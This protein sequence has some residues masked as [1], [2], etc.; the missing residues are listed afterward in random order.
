MMLAVAAEDD[1]AGPGSCH[2]VPLVPTNGLWKDYCDFVY[3]RLIDNQRAL[4][5]WVLSFYLTIWTS[6]KRCL[7]S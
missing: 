7:S 2:A 5:P 3:T 6:P 1:R 4:H